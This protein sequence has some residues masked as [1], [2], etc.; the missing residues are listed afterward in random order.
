MSS[1]PFVTVA[2]NSHDKLIDCCRNSQFY[3]VNILRLGNLKRVLKKQYNDL[4][5][6]KD[7]LFDSDD[8]IVDFLEARDGETK[9]QQKPT[10]GATELRSHLLE[11]R[12]DPKCRH[13][14]V[15]AS[16]SRA[17]LNC[18]WESF[19]NI[20]AFHQISPSFLDY[21]H[22]F[23]QSELPKDYSMTGFFSEDSLAISEDDTLKIPELGRSGRELR[24]S[25]LLRSVELTSEED[26]GNNA[27]KKWPWRVRQMAIYHSFDFVTGRALWLN[28]KTNSLMKE[29]IT[30]AVVELPELKASSLGNLASRFEATLATHLIFADWCDSNW[31]CCI[32]DFE[33]DL[34]K[35]LIKGKTARISQA[36]ESTVVRL[37]RMMSLQSQGTI[38]S[39]KERGAQTGDGVIQSSQ[40]GLG[41]LISKVQRS[42]SKLKD[43]QDDSLSQLAAVSQPITGPPQC[44]NMLFESMKDLKDLDTFSFGQLQNL[45]HMSEQLHEMSLVI[46]LDVQTLRDI[47]EYYRGLIKNDNV[48]KEIRENCKSSVARFIWKV[49]RVAKNL[50]IR[51]TQLES[52]KTWLGDGKALF[53]GILQFKSLRINQML[54]EIAAE[55][56]Q[57]MQEIANKTEKETE[58][59]HIITFVTLAFLPGTFV[60]TFFQS[61]LFKWK[62][63]GHGMSDSLKFNWIAFSFF[64][65]ICFPLMAVIFGMWWFW[66]RR[67]NRVH[68]APGEV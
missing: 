42:M 49:D 18:S 15:Q 41:C 68:P 58:S 43:P 2:I 65:A 51:L 40:A 10:E 23:G 12:K 54:T 33:A 66:L 22:S 8:E 9:Y 20:L 31:R 37:K 29:T 7:L 59:M 46:Q 52:M 4:N 64:A 14:F 27:E 63:D 19:S 5:T 39:R 13:I 16:D 28:I 47:K 35:I 30:E 1:T 17:P 21:V 61:G 50:E 11:N 55:Q 24:V 26:D 45:H 25:Y 44:V 60:A 32:N 53:D 56:S 67:R 62:E 6:S 48:P 34:S 57:R 38:Q 3:P 36:D